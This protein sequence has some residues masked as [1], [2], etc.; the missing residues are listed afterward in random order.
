MSQT[1]SKPIVNGATQKPPSTLKLMTT[2]ALR[3]LGYR[4]KQFNEDEF[5]QL[6]GIQVGIACI[7]AFIL[8]T[9]TMAMLSVFAVKIMS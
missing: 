5:Q 3:I 4:K 7:L 2:V 1:E 9:A 8:F 6:S